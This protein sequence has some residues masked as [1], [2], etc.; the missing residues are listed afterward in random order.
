MKFLHVMKRLGKSEMFNKKIDG[1]I[2]FV[3]KEI[4]PVS[5][6]LNFFNHITAQKIK[7]STLRNKMA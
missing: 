4:R 5:R 2:T 7:I 1:T 6:H 3:I